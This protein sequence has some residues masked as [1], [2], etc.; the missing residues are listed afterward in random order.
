MLSDASLDVR[1]CV[2]LYACIPFDSS[3]CDCM[4]NDR[5]NELPSLGLLIVIWSLADDNDV[6]TLIFVSV[7]VQRIKFDGIRFGD[8]TW[9]LC[10]INCGCLNMCASSAAVWSTLPFRF[11]QICS[12]SSGIEF[13]L[14]GRGAIRFFRHGT[15]GI[16]L[17]RKLDIGPDE[18][19]EFN[20]LVELYGDAEIVCGRWLLWLIASKRQSDCVTLCMECVRNLTSS[21]A[22]AWLPFGAKRISFKPTSPMVKSSS[23]TWLPSTVATKREKTELI[24]LDSDIPMPHTHSRRTYSDVGTQTYSDRAAYWCTPYVIHCSIWSLRQPGPHTVDPV[25]DRLSHGMFARTVRSH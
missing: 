8:E 21:G 23:N 3:S 6:S 7:F 4:D 17:V 20:E 1:E 14:G 19:V 13:W 9:K 2:R 10:R 5:P 11:S 25:G 16:L 12:L 18:S 22:V 15:D 24:K